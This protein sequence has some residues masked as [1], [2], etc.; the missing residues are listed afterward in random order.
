MCTEYKKEWGTTMLPNQQFINQQPIP[1]PTVARNNTMK[2]AAI[3]LFAIGFCL[4]I[5]A[6]LP[7]IGIAFGLIG[8]CCDIIGFVCL[9]LI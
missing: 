2:T 1:H 4:H 7:L 5:M 3:I 8:L 9:C 6:L